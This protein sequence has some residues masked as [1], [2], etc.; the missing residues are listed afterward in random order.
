MPLRPALPGSFAASPPPP[1]PA[2]AHASG[3]AQ[4][5]GARQTVSCVL[6]CRDRAHALPQLLPLLSDTLTE[7]G[8]PWELIV[9]DFGSRDGTDSLMSAWGE[10]PGFRYLS[11]DGPVALEEAFETGILAA[12]GDAVILLD[13]ALPHTPELIPQMILQW[14]SEARLV[15]AARDAGGASRLLRWDE[16]LAAAQT[17]RPDMHLP[18]ECMQLSLLD[19]RLVDWLV[20]AG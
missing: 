4:L 9:V 2:W 17:A 3:W 14:E 18:P 7:C 6:P 1:E 5:S 19:R 15:Y 10:L 16:A 20:Q 11:T 13:P 8:Y 12:R